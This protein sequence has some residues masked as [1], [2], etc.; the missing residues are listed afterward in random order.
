MIIAVINCKGG[1]GKTTTSVNLSASL[2]LLGYRVLLIDLDAQANAS[3]SLGISPSELSPSVRDMLFD[4]A[5]IDSVVRNT[6]TAGL[7]LITGESELASSDLN[8]ADMRD[9]EKLLTQALSP[10]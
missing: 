10:V 2:A 3:V 4:D 6:N 5:P 1:T 9:R 8:L 7:D